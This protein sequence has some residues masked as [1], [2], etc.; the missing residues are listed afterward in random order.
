[1]AAVAETVAFAGGRMPLLST[2][3][4][5]AVSITYIYIYLHDYE[6]FSAAYICCGVRC[7]EPIPVCNRPPSATPNE[8]VMDQDGWP[9]KTM[10]EAHER[11]GQPTL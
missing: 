7:S 6:C 4:D 9:I 8:A 5:S 2:L 10:G 11:R 1:M 3:N